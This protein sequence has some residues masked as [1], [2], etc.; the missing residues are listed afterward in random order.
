MCMS[1]FRFSLTVGGEWRNRLQSPGWLN[2]AREMSGRQ[3]QH[4]AQTGQRGCSDK[5]QT[6]E[7]QPAETWLLSLRKIPVSL[8]HLRWH[9]HLHVSPWKMMLEVLTLA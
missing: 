4:G 9:Q 1:E 8:T 7:R 6:R 2:A 3:P 5:V